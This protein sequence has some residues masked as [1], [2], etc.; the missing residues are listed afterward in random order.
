[1]SRIDI[2]QIDRS[3]TMMNET[4]K[5][6]TKK[7]IDSADKMTKINIRAA[8]EGLGEKIDIEA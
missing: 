4:L 3:I 8:V 1:M 7:S 6:I 2:E 5:N